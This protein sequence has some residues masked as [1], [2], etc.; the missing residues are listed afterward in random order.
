MGFLE[1]NNEAAR[2]NKEDALKATSADS[3][4]GRKLQ[5]SYQRWQRIHRYRL[6]LFGTSWA[7]LLLSLM[8]DTG[9]RRL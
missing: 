8:L 3:A 9:A 2:L 6:G 4:Q 1:I 7:L 5:E